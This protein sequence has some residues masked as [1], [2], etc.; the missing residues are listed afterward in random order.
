[1]HIP[2]NIMPK[3]CIPFLQQLILGTQPRCFT[4]TITYLSLNRPTTSWCASVL[5]RECTSWNKTKKSI[6]RRKGGNCDMYKI[7]IHGIIQHLFHSCGPHPLFPILFA[8]RHPLFPNT[9]LKCTFPTNTFHSGL[10]YSSRLKSQFCQIQNASNNLGKKSIAL[11]PLLAL[12][13]IKIVPALG[14]SMLRVNR[15]YLEIYRNCEADLA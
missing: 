4:L 5:Y 12:L 3:F 10:T 8:V 9:G 6:W 15:S 11:I 13:L 2:C 1:M 14:V 7:I